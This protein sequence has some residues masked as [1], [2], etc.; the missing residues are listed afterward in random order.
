MYLNA[1]LHTFPSSFRFSVVTAPLHSWLAL[2]G[3]TS[4][5]GQSSVLQALNKIVC[6]YNVVQMNSLTL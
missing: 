4:E 5:T 6:A 2:D 3:I 1:I